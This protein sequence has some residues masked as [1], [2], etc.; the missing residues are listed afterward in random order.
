MG[1]GHV[2]LIGQILGDY[3]VLQ[4][5]GRGGMGVVFK[6]RHRDLDRT[7]A[8]KMVLRGH[9]ATRL[10]MERFRAEAQAVASLDHPGIVPI[11]R[12]GEYDGTP[13]FTM[14]LVEGG[15][16]R[17]R[18]ADYQGR[19]RRTAALMRELA[20]AVHHAHQRG[21]LHRDLKPSNILLDPN[22]RPMVTDF[23]V[24]R[25]L[26]PTETTE[27]A[28]KSK[29]RP[30]LPV[31]RLTGTG[32]VVGTPSYMSPEQASSARE[33]TTATDIYSLGAILYELLTGQPPFRSDNDLQTMLLVMEQEPKP[34]HQIDPQVDRNL[35]QICLKCLAKDPSQRYSSAD[36]L[37][38]DLRSYLAGEPISL[39]PPNLATFFTEWM[40]H[41]FKAAGWIVGV[42][43]VAGLLFGLLGWIALILPQISEATQIGYSRPGLGERPWLAFNWDPP[44]AV[45]ASSMIGLFALLAN[46][47]LAI[48]MLAR[49]RDRKAD[50]IAGLVTGLIVA[51]SALPWSGGWGPVAAFSLHPSR[52]DLQMIIDAALE[53]EG[54]DVETDARV[55][56]RETYPDLEGFS[57]AERSEIL[58][59]RIY[60]DQLLG[61]PIGLIVG[62]GMLVMF[63]TAS[64]VLTTSW[65]GVLRRRHDGRL[66]PALIHYFEIALTGTALLM[67]TTFLMIQVVGHHEVIPLRTWRIP[68]CY[69]T[70]AAALIASLTHLPQG[71]RIAAH[72]AWMVWLGYTLYLY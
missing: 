36:A 62:T 25:R 18:M 12:I 30:E 50:V 41:H 40:H 63:T 3:H 4:E 45:V 68:F 60:L 5:L 42:G 35:E 55:R 70:L 6:A 58:G 37:A 54:Q 48:G 28:R 11:Y 38:K 67:L 69:I 21:I 24:A 26:D 51:V 47:G 56:L 7:V 29:A 17:D 27:T 14:K 33:L 1:G 19:P 2:R 16:L 10:E 15:R 49:P 61:I 39:R 71:A 64:T 32:G 57:L 52:A 46:T 72:M 9:L 43:A 66:T 13:Y 31:S 44:R 34:P 53:D 65:S 59:A 23:G 22:G 20:E 8:L